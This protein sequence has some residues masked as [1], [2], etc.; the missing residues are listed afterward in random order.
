MGPLSVFGF[1]RAGD[2]GGVGSGRKMGMSLAS[3]GPP[4]PR[5][6]S[7]LRCPGPHRAALRIQWAVENWILLTNPALSMGVGS[8]S[9]EG[10]RVCAVLH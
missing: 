5:S 8:G 9:W 10:A 3:R 1:P 7:C 6:P 2:P 4:G